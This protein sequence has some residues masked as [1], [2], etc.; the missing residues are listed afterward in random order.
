MNTIGF[1]KKDNILMNKNG[2]KTL[3]FIYINDQCID[4]Y[5]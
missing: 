5:L 4:T 3:I 1:I 2:Y